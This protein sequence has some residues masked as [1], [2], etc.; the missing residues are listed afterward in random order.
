MGY[1][2]NSCKPTSGG[3]ALWLPCGVSNDIYVDIN[4]NLE[5]NLIFFWGILIMD[6]A[7]WSMFGLLVAFLNIYLSYGL[8]FG[9]AAGGVA[10]NKIRYD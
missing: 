9:H 7:V 2:T 10:L 8:N 3:A 1:L 5:F 6:L 4:F